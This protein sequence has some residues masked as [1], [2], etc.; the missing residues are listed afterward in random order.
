MENLGR[1]TDTLFLCHIKNQGTI[2][3]A[4][5]FAHPMC[6]WSPWGWE[7]TATLY[8]REIPSGPVIRSS[9]RFVTLFSGGVMPPTRH[10]PHSLRQ[11]KWSVCVGHFASHPPGNRAIYKLYDVQCTVGGQW[12]ARLAK[13]GDKQR[14]IRALSRPPPPPQLRFNGFLTTHFGCATLLRST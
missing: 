1:T 9:L 14:E 3:V 4:I 12:I 13:Y 6:P 11:D 10:V 8:E 7:Q 2:F 5:S